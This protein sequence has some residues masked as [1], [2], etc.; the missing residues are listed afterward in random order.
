MAWNASSVGAIIVNPMLGLSPSLVRSRRPVM[1]NAEI[2]MSNEPSSC[3]TVGTSFSG[4]NL[5][6]LVGS[7]ERL[8]EEGIS[9]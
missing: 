3:K 5:G 6:E 2:K 1:F 7:W 8:S 4:S 9:I